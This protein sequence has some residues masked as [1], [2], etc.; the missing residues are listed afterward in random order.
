MVSCPLAKFGSMVGRGATVLT[1]KFG[2]IV[3][4]SVGVAAG[5]VEVG[6]DE[7]ATGWERSEPVGVHETGRKGVGVGD[8]FG[9]DV[10]IANGS[11]PS[12]GALLPHP[13]SNNAVMTMVRQLGF[14][15]K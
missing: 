4:I 1:R 9:A 13:A 15:L 7:S 5:G 6:E 2:S 10:T 3:G 14:I 12:A 11:D 8:G